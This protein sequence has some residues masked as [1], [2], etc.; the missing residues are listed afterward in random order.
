MSG[1]QPASGKTLKTGNEKSRH[2]I[3]KFLSMPWW[4]GIGAIAAVITIGGAVAAVIAILPSEQHV[5]QNTSSGPVSFNSLSEI[6]IHR[7]G[8]DF[9]YPSGWDQDYL[10]SNRDGAGFVN[11]NDQAVSIREYGTHGGFSSSSPTIFD[12]ETWWKS[13]IR[14]LKDARII[15]E[16]ASG[17]TVEYANA[18]YPIDAWRAIYEYVDDHGRPM[19][20]M[21]KVTYA[22]GRE[23]DL[24]M[25][26]PTRVFPRYREAFLQLS[27]KLLLLAQCED[28][29]TH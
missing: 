20:D 19:T 6:T 9:Y 2:G 10:P 13:Y 21:I 25:E 24:V 22:N 12:V 26:A 8:F 14:S 1:T 7:Y 5:T 4:A 18:R 3:G 27:D 15:E 28:C 29:S 17:A 11:P 16:T 23:V